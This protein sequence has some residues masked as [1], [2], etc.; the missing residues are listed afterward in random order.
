MLIVTYKIKGKAQN[1]D[2]NA[3]KNEFED[4]AEN[5]EKISVETLSGP[6][7]SQANPQ[8]VQG[9]D[10]IAQVSGVSDEPLGISNQPEHPIAPTKP[11]ISKKRIII[12]ALIGLALIAAGLLA[13]WYTGRSNDAKTPSN[14]TLSSVKL[15]GAEVSLIDGSAETSANNK[16]WMKLTVGETVQQGHY[17]RTASDGRLIIKLDDGSAIRLNSAA[18]IK[19]DRLDAK[20]ILITN[21]SGEVY[22]RLVKSDRIFTVSVGG[23]GYRAMGTAYKTINMQST[24]GVEVYESTVKVQGSIDVAEGKYYYDIAS[25]AAQQQKVTDIPTDKLKQDAFVRW[26]YEQDKGSTEFKNKLGYLT[27]IDEPAAPSSTTNAAA[28]QTNT[29]ASISI[30]GTRTDNG[31]QITWTLSN[32]TA[33]KGFKVVKGSAANPSYGKDDAVFVEATARSYTWKLNN[34]ATYHFRVCLYGENGCSLY[35][36]DIAVAAP[37]YSV[38]EPSG[39]VSLSHGTS[40]NFGWTLNGTAPYGFKLVWSANTGPTYPTRDGDKYAY[41]GDA[42]AREGAISETTG[43]YHVR[44]CLYTSGHGC[45]IYS[46]EITVTL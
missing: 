16:S 20:N 30:K 31:I 19:I 13:Y 42:A 8:A 3:T 7:E 10:A 34:G 21:I 43:T 2:N 33:S 9:D 23:K 25:E 4:E 46:N 15:M 27:K 44:V 39:T 41:Y 26:N 38:E 24:K 6:L 17:Y 18:T 29:S 40:A 5:I 12:I 37:T 32:V 28:T 45:T 22:T 35:S 14:S 1:M 11:K 36:N